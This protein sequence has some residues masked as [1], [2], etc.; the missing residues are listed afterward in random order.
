MTYSV[1]QVVV[2]SPRSDGGPAVQPCGVDASGIGYQPA[3]LSVGLFDPATAA[4][5]DANSGP[6]DYGEA[7]EFWGFAFVTVLTFWLVSRVAGTILSA[8]R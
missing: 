8:I 6:I 5:L 7:A 3:L 4:L 1:Q 2:C